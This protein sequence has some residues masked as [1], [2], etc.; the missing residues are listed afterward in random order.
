MKI[1]INNIL[2]CTLTHVQIKITQALRVCLLYSC[3]L[4]KRSCTD[5]YA[6]SMLYCVW[7]AS[8]SI[9]NMFVK[10]MDLRLSTCVWRQKW[11]NYFLHLCQESQKSINFAFEREF[12]TLVKFILSTMQQNLGKL[13]FYVNICSTFLFNSSVYFNFFFLFLQRCILNLCQ[14]L[15]HEMLRLNELIF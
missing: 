11:R 9:L 10:I 3:W 1:L 4:I 7:V 8:C 12:S 13:A 15:C 2:F 6:H 5:S 14:I